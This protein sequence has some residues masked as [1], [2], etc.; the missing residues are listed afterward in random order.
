MPIH[1]RLVVFDLDGTLV[2]CESSWVHVHEHFGLDND[3][4][5]ELYM[6]GEIDDEEFMRRDIALWKG[7]KPDITVKDVEEILNEIKV[8]PGARKLF[9]LLRNAGIQTAIVSGGLMPLA[10]RVAFDLQINHVLANGLAIEKGGRLIGHG[11]LEVEL[12]RKDLPMERLMKRLGFDRE[13]V[14]AVGNSFIDAPMLE[15]AGLGIAFNPLDE[16]VV[17]AADVVVEGT[18]LIALAPYLIPE[19]RARP[20]GGRRRSRRGR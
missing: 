11:L 6:N 13:R 15:L 9:S 5:L 17:E 3:A 7:R 19:S 4:S 10:R 18:D 12:N 16:G 14:A 8:Y 20:Q 1:L 2:D